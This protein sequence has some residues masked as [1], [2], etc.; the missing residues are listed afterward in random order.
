MPRAG[1]AAQTSDGVRS[2]LQG[3]SYVSR[4]R[5]SVGFLVFVTTFLI[6]YRY[7]MSL[8]ARAGAPFWL[9][10]SVLL[11]ALLL[12]RRSAWFLYLGV[13]LPLRLVVAIP[14]GT[15]LWFLLTAFANDSFK[16]VLAATLLRRFSRGRSIR[17]DS[18]QE[19]WLYLLAAVVMAPA[20]SA[21]FGAASWVLRGREFWTAWRSWYFG[22]ALANI[23]FTPLLLC[24]ARDWRKL[25]N[26]TFSA[27]LQVFA[28]FL[29]LFCAVQFGLQFGLNDPSTPDFY[30]YLPVPL[31]L[32][33]AVRFGPLGASAALTMMSM[34]SIAAMASNRLPSMSA[35]TSLLSMQLFLM[36]IGV[37]IMSLSVLIE[38]QR[39]TENSLRESETPFRKMVDTAP[40]MI[41]IS[42]SDGRA[43]L[44][45][46]GWL[47][48]TGRSLEQEIG[49]G[50]AAGRCATGQ[51]FYSQ[52][53]SGT[54]FD[55]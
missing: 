24:I 31:L 25:V 10:D 1:A 39:R 44:F 47:D 4:L 34:I 15:P 46:R 32:L 9:P 13:S 55:R 2:T 21:L 30:D 29:G 5:P 49:F 27:Y 52:A 19:F 37:P 51:G 36:V 17:F 22:D 53:V 8:S 38:Q 7:S 14:T 3:L 23:L 42:A 33:A 6:T 45:N 35:D 40:T 20:A 18:L 43:S 12:S 48:F 54:R 41:W 11:C 50:G 26:A 28:L 16:A